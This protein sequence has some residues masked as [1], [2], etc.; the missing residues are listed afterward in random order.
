MLAVQNI[1]INSA[2][3]QK[4]LSVWIVGM[5]SAGSHRWEERSCS[6]VPQEDRSVGAV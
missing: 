4:D 6:L 2:I 5:A 1:K 3:I